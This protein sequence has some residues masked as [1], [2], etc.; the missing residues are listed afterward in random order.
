MTFFD[1]L[2]EE[3]QVV[4]TIKASELMST[5]ASHTKNIRYKSYHENKEQFAKA[6]LAKRNLPGPA[7]VNN[8]LGNHAN[9]LMD[10]DD[11]GVKIAGDNKG[12]VGLANGDAAV[13]STGK[14]RGIL[15]VGGIL[16]VGSDKRSKRDQ[17]M[18]KLSSPSP[19]EDQLKTT[20]VLSDAKQLGTDALDEANHYKQEL[21]RCMLEKESF[22]KKAHDSRRLRKERDH[23]RKRKA[24]LQQELDEARLHAA[25]IQQELDDTKEAHKEARDRADFFESENDKMSYHLSRL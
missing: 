13:V 23:Y 12:E 14:K 6:L 24:T 16:N 8:F 17:K 25:R 19:L 4:A 21:F 22:A 10:G 11:N 20:E 7:T 2:T 9:V 18:V 5:F 1:Q 15:K 3:E